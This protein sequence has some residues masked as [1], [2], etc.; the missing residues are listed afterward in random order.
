MGSVRENLQQNLKFY[1]KQRGI[2][3]KQLAQ[4]LNV[5][6]AAV[7]NW[8]KGKNAPDIEVLIQLCHLLEVPLERLLETEAAPEISGEDRVFFEKYCR[9]DSSGKKMLGL[10]V[11][12][13]LERLEVAPAENIVPIR[14]E[15]APEII[16]LP[17]YDLPV[18]A[19]TG[20]FLDDSRREEI[21][22]ERSELTEKADFALRI[23]GDSME[24]RYH[25]G[26]ILLVQVQEEVQP[27][28]LGIFVLNGQG[29]FKK[30]GK[31]A[32]VS[33]NPRYE[34]IPIHEYDQIS[35]IGKVIGILS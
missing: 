18:S 8:V 20:I 34:P 28:A 3:Q 11:D 24:P 19:G 25:D 27:G 9:L 17:F 26:E 29:Y 10:L 13:E 31:N 21:A 16:Q 12:H 14:P 2:S 22:A 7:T 30:L 33:L 5:S 6:Q 32:L 35:C 4:Q 23:S 1:F 15:T